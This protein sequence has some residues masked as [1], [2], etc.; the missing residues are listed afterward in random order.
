MAPQRVT[1]AI[2]ALVRQGLIVDHHKEHDNI[3]GRYG[4]TP[5]KIAWPHASKLGPAARQAKRAA[6]ASHVGAI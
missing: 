6:E 5:S 1:T 3:D 2:L 4:W